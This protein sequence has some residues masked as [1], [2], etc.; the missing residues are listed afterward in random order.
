MSVRWS[1]SAPRAC[2][3]DMYSTVPS[4]VPSFV[5][6]VVNWYNGL[7]VIEAGARPLMTNLLGLP[8]D[9]VRVFIKTVIRREA[10]AAELDRLRSGYTNLQLVISLLV[11]TLLIPCVNSL[12]V[13]FKERGLKASVVMLLS[14]TGYALIAGGLVNHVCQLLGVTFG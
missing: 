3:G 9:A 1:T 5:I 10:G 12:V 11:M 4:V 8:E 13:L 7:D 6:F 14:S 2:S